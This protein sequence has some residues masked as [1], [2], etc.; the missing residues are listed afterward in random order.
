MSLAR[1]L[2]RIEE[3]VAEDDEVIRRHP[4]T[5]LPTITHR[6]GLMEALDVFAE[7]FGEET[8]A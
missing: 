3:L 6:N 2:Q 7:E 8:V 4:H 1:A 5:N